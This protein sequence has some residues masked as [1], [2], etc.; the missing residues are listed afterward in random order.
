RTINPT[1]DRWS[2]RIRG[3]ITRYTDSRSPR[4]TAT[5]EST[6]P[7]DTSTARTTAQLL[8]TGGRCRV[9]R[10]RTRAR[11]RQAFTWTALGETPR[12]LASSAAGRARRTR[13]SKQAHV[14]PQVGSRTS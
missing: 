9:H 3:E 5:H 4:W 12:S 13:P 11:T 1:V 2:V 8:S 6:H 7:A 10:A 14:A